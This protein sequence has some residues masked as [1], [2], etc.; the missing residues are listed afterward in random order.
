MF[1]ANDAK[2]FTGEWEEEETVTAKHWM[3]PNT[4]FEGVPMQFNLTNIYGYAVS[5]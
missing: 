4:E 2:Y 3:L 1:Q 5:E